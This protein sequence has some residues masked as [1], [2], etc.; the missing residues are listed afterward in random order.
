MSGA[1]LVC[2]SASGVGK[3]TVVAGLCRLYR[4]GGASVAPFKAQNMSNHAAVTADGG[5][6][7]RA[8]AMQA[9]AAGV[10]VETAMNPI[11]LKPS[12]E[13]TSHVVVNGREI[14]TTDAEGWG[15]RT[16]AL[17][18]VVVEAF[19]SLRERFDVV[20]AEGAGGAAEINLLDRDLVN[21]P[22]AAAT[23]TPVL[24]VVDIDRGGAFAAAHGTIDLV[25]DHLR[26]TIGG[27]VFNRF[28]GDP[29]LLDPGIRDLEARTGVPVLGVLP[30]LG[31]RPL[32]GVEDSLDV[33]GAVTAT[34]S[35]DPIRIA[36][37]R[38]PHLANP[39][40]FDP[41]IVEA[42]VDF[43]WADRGSDLN[44]ADVVIL[45][46]SRATV[47]DL[48]WMFDRGFEDRILAPVGDLVGICAG[49]Q[50]LGD[51]IVDHHES[52]LGTAIGFGVTPLVTEFGADKVVRR[53]SGTS[54]GRTVHG[55]QIH[56]GRTPSVGTPWVH[57]G[58]EHGDEA[59]GFVH[60]DGRVRTT[61]LHG[62]FD[63]DDFRTA[64]LTDVAR[65]YGRTYDPAP[66]PF[67]EE[68]TRQHDRL[69]DW[70]DEFVDVGAITAMARTAAPAGRGPGW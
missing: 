46:G 35:L 59:D 27:I 6:V 54:D 37:V 40:D 22:L 41:L 25:P 49:Q 17:R 15:D 67:A 14:D 20:V 5:E 19:D 60:P 64:F 51:T 57:F 55:Y 58:D 52:R 30:H 21:L 39:S 24:L 66:R 63:D 53:R 11:L 18:S 36:A 68:M 43:W 32:L 69:A 48:D 42:D 28:R 7:G 62:I 47:R 2:G 65:R 70:I 13:R 50:M 4:R 9:L 45:P 61:S 12:G 56:A 23:G 44:G 3:S 31:D 34:R 8:Q 26:A 10:D 16:T 1:V 38:F 33:S 29:S